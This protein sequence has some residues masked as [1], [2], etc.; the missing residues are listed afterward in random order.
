MNL[1]NLLSGLN[2]A[3]IMSSQCNDQNSTWCY[4]CSLTRGFTMLYHSLPALVI[5][6]LA[7]E[8]NYLVYYLNHLVRPN[9]PMSMCPSTLHSAL[10]VSSSL[11]IFEL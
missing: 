3:I 4:T 7:N 1:V 11:L 9:T 5:Y 6:T 10:H 8:E 2:S